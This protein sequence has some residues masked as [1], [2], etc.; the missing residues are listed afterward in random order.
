MTN[1]PLDG[2]Y[3]RAII[4]SKFEVIINQ[5][6]AMENTPPTIPP[7][8]PPPG[9][10]GEDK[11]VAIVSYL[12]PIGFIVAIILHGSK[13]TKLGAYHLRQ[14][15]GFIL[16]VITVSF[17]I[18]MMIFIIA[19]IPFVH[20]VLFLLVPLLWFGF[21]VIGFVLWLMGLMAAINGQEKPIPVV[22]EHFQ[23]WFGT[24]FE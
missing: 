2:Y 14:T 15:L 12:T 22:G 20:L 16:M 21:T 24:A 7:T 4:G 1:L 5:L 13:K 9:A 3:P 10:S 18:G 23:K 8:A 17:A 6:T 19:L 11:T